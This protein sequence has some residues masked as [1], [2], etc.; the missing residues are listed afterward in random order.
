MHIGIDAAQWQGSFGVHNQESFL[1]GVLI[2]LTA[3]LFTL[4]NGFVIVIC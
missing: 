4:V 3:K 1:I 2:R